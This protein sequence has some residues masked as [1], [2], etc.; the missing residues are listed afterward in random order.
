MACRKVLVIVLIFF[1]Q[2]LPLLVSVEAIS[3]ASLPLTNTTEAKVRCIESERNGLLRV[4]QSLTDPS[5]HLA[6]WIGKE[7]CIW[8]GV[9]CDVQTGNFIRL[10]L[11]DT[12]GNCYQKKMGYLISDISTCLGGKISP[13]LLDLKHLEYLDL[14]EMTSKDLPLPLSW[15]LLKNYNILTSPIHLSLVFLLHLGTCRIYNI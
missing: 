2:S 3:T 1:L 6:S 14:G 7:C 8:K 11:K 12:S 13:A 10:D 5:D 4:E 9:S 15:V